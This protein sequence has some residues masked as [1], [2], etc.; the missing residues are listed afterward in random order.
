M[1]IFIAAVAITAIY[2]SIRVAARDG[3]RQKPFC[4]E[5]YDH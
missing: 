2:A 3:Y 5:L 1:T 4:A